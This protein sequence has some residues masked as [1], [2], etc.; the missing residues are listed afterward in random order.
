MPAP[1]AS[2]GVRKRTRL[3]SRRISPSSGCRAPERALIKVDL[4]APLSPIT[5]RKSTRL[6]SSHSQISYAVFCLKKKNNH[7]TPLFIGEATLLPCRS[8]SLIHIS[9]SNQLTNH[10]QPSHAYLA[11]MRI[12]THNHLSSAVAD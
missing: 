8:H 9:I 4:P 7:V 12:H 11:L 10:E 6:N 1:R 3:P 5:D 2:P